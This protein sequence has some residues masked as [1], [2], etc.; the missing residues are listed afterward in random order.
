MYVLALKMNVSIL[1]YILD[2]NN[3]NFE[4]TQFIHL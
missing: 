1:I 3:L 4:G 2:R